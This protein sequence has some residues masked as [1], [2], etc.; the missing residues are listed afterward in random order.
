MQSLDY[1]SRVHHSTECRKIR[2]IILTMT[3]LGVREKNLRPSVEQPS[4][5]SSMKNMFIKINKVIKKAASRSTTDKV[6]TASYRLFR[7]SKHYR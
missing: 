3:M 2:T 1:F 4:G 5:H 7:Y 6:K